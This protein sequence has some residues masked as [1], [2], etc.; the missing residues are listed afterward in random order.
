MGLGLNFINVLL[1]AFT[2]VDHKNIKKTVK[3]S[4][5]LM[6]L[7]STSVKAARR[8]LMKL[9]LGLQSTVLTLCP[10]TETSVYSHLLSV[11]KSAFNDVSLNHFVLPKFCYKN[12]FVIL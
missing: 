6:L 12:D 5:F 11:F 7:G 9:T 3:F 4:I 2:L 10:Y 8:M 1:T